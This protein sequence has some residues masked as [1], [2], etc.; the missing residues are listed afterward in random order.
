MPLTLY[1]ELHN[2]FPQA[3]KRILKDSFEIYKT[4]VASTSHAEESDFEALSCFPEV[5]SCE[6]HYYGVSIYLGCE[7]DIISEISSIGIR[8]SEG[9]KMLILF[10]VSNDC[11]W[12]KLD[13]DGPVYKDFPEY[14]WNDS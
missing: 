11:L 2:L 1:K 9:L 7:A 6:D 13:A 8:I 5:F 12:L 4:L 10:A 14:D 3:F